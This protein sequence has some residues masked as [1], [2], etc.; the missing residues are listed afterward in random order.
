M[1]FFWFELSSPPNRIQ[2]QNLSQSRSEGQT[3][4]H[5]TM[6]RELL[7]ISSVLGLIEAGQVAEEEMLALEH[8]RV[9]AIADMLNMLHQ[10]ATTVKSEETPLAGSKPQL[11]PL[12]TL[13]Q[14]P[15][16]TVMSRLATHD[17]CATVEDLMSDERLVK[18]IR[19]ICDAPTFTS[20]LNEKSF[21]RLV[22]LLCRWLCSGPSPDGG[23][24]QIRQA[25]L[26]LHEGVRVFDTKVLRNP[27][28][29]REWRRIVAAL[30]NI[31]EDGRLAADMAV[32]PPEVAAF[33]HLIKSVSSSST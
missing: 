20:N 12:V 30:E 17:L 32:T 4:Y 5:T 23:L 15:L 8:N 19:R 10:H 21:E 3:F 9:A 22:P 33:A 18:L 26:L 2:G 27:S 13:L 25:F 24:G 29:R 31:A 7:E 1:P 11:T 6:N 28:L 16:E 14:V